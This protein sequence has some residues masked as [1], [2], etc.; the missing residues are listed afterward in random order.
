[1]Q[2][3]KRILIEGITDIKTTLLG[4]LFK[5]A[6]SDLERPYAEY[7]R[8]KQQGTLKDMTSEDVDFIKPEWMQCIDLARFETEKLHADLG[9][10]PASETDFMNTFWLMARD[11]FKVLER[12]HRVCKRLAVTPVPPVRTHGVRRKR[13]DHND[14]VDDTIQPVR[15]TGSPVSKKRKT[16]SL[17]C[18]VGVRFA[19]F[20]PKTNSFAGFVDMELHRKSV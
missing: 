1:M 3:S 12:Y 10:S 16:Q 6:T 15:V 14:G 18:Q 2:N 7:H 9:L 17:L 13:H 5:L 20:V 4:D 8:A 19:D 11:R